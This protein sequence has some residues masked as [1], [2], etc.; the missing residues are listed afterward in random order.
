MKIEKLKKTELVE[1][2]KSIG[3]DTK[4]KNVPELRDAI[5]K[6]EREEIDSAISK[7][8]GLEL[9]KEKIGKL[10]DD[11]AHNLSMKIDDRKEEMKRDDNSHYLIYRVLG[12]SNEEGTLIDVYQN[13]GRFLYKYAG[14]FLEEAATLCMFFSNRDGKKTLID[15]TIGSK[16]KTFEIDFLNSNDAVELKWRDATTDGDHITKE[17]T[18]VKAIKESGFKPIRVMFYYPQREQAIKIQETLK[19]IYHGVDGEYYAGDDA[20]DY[21]KEVSGYDLKGI[22]VEIAE[23]RDKND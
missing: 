13:T 8:L 20:W 16:P 19:T 6:L 22:L 11:Y 23:S 10:A 18:R 14:S 21:L 9:L 17:H 2:C 3:L 5:Y 4:G 12:I 15:N 7:G 1:Y